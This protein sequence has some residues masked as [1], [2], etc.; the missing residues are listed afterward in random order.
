LE[1]ENRA[2][3]DGLRG[4]RGRGKPR[5][6]L[7]KYDWNPLRPE[8]R[9]REKRR[10]VLNHRKKK[11]RKRKLPTWQRKNLLCKNASLKFPLRKKGGKK[12]RA[13]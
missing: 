13:E 10:A 2:P 12:G 5:T 9:K 6:R 8:K 3:L 7:Q 11:K 1:G 4:G